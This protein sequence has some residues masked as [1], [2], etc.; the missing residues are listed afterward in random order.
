M[1][2]PGPRPTGASPVI[3]SRR[4]VQA[5]V[6]LVAGPVGA[7]LALLGFVLGLPEVFF[8]VAVLLPAP[9]C[10]W[11]ALGRRGSERAGWSTITAGLVVLSLWLVWL[12][13]RGVLF[14]FLGAAL[15]GIAA[16]GA[17]SA[18]HHVPR[19]GQSRLPRSTRHVRRPVLFVNP[20]SG[21]GTAARVDLVAEARRRGIRVVELGPD[22]DLPALAR[23]EVDS[24]AD[25]L[26]AAGGDGTLAQVA[27]VAV[28]FGLP[29]VC[30]PAGTR[31]H[32]A[33]DLGL[34]RDDPVGALDAFRAAH[35]L[36]VDVAEVN[37]RLF[38]N[39]VSVGV[40]GEV[41]AAEQYR[42]HKIGTALAVLPDL[43][44]PDAEPVG[45]HVVDDRGEHHPDAVVLLVSNNAY[46]LG[47][48][49]GFGSRPSLRDGR[50]GVVLVEPSAG[51]LS[52]LHV[53]SWQAERFE[54]DAV[55]ALNVGL[56]GESIRLEPPLSFRVRPGVL[57]VRLPLDA[58]GVSPAALRPRLG[59]ARVE[60][61]WS[62]ARG[63]PP[64]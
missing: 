3:S 5:A 24:G 35:S 9:W 45:V 13:D 57:R 29:F 23:S 1:D 39:N 43:V 21:G 63:V 2:V 6:A 4:R 22:S 52:P 11:M 56:D 48:R 30:V 58:P 51:L 40:Y 60:E 49:L 31:N 32:F 28:E 47:P 59:P 50:L 19:S 36:R 25:C 15:V 16:A 12:S 17:A 18:L 14:V 61:L 42:D 27:G 37:G 44:G 38:L 55:T 33:L 54:V 62:I 20:R 41:V 53:H 10:L 46:D 26:G 8:A 7:A 34:D 64:G